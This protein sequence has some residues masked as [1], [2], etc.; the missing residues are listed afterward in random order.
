[1]SVA[2]GA[3]QNGLSPLNTDRSCTTD[4]VSA[5]KAARV[6][7]RPA[8]KSYQRSD[9]NRCAAHLDSSTV[10]DRRRFSVV[11]PARFSRLTGHTTDHDRERS[12]RS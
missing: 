9:A 5:T 3:P 4:E 8:L 11:I 10:S 2:G 7:D 1:M 6:P 12:A